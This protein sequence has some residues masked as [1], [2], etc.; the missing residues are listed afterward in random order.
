MHFSLIPK[1]K[2]HLLIAINDNFHPDCVFV[3]SI[4]A[5]RLTAMRR[6]NFWR[7]LSS[8]T[9][10]EPCSRQALFGCGFAAMVV[11]C[12]QMNEDVR[13]TFEIKAIPWTHSR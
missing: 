12:L 13:Q 10:D 8:V 7:S 6:R 9:P 1:N 11:A 5:P 2:P 4:A 3:D